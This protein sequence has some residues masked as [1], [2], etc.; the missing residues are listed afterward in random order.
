MTG[1]PNQPIR[2]AV[3][4][5]GPDD[6]GKV[7]SRTARVVR[8]GCYV[9]FVRRAAE[10]RMFDCVS[11]GRFP[12]KLPGG[13][14]KTRVPKLRG[15]ERH[16]FYATLEAKEAGADWLV[17]GTDTDRGLGGSKRHLPKACVQK[18]GQLR[19]GYEK[20]TNFRPETTK[21]GFV[22]L[23]PLVKLES[24]LLAD[25][26]AFR[27]VARFPRGALP[28]SPE[29]LYG[30]TDAK[31]LLDKLFHDRRREAP[32]TAAKARLAAAATPAVLTQQCPISYPRFHQQVVSLLGPRRA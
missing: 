31:A 13:F 28:K 32:D 19:S 10:P 21:V 24:W 22:C 2:V 23:V 18:Y 5:E 30:S 12:K 4:G 1:K 27:A 16:S 9:A 29:K 25:E 14:R 8:E 15:F 3:R 6:Y 20:A 11:A 26:E 7:D 17:I